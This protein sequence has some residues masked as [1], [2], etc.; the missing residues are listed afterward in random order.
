MAEEVPEVEP[1][2]R[3]GLALEDPPAP[4][5]GVRGGPG[6]VRQDGL[7]PP[8]MG[9]EVPPPRAEPVFGRPLARAARPGHAGTSPDQMHHAGLG[10]IPAGPAGTAGPAAEVRSEE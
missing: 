7:E 1:R 4:E 10:D 6:Q 5:A 9:Q 2:I 8:V 3:I